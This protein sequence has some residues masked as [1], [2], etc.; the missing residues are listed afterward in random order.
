MKIKLLVGALV[1]M[2]IVNLATIGSFLYTRMTRPDPLQFISPNEKMMPRN[3]MDER[4]GAKLD[5]EQWEQL[6][7]LLYGFREETKE[8]NT[9]IANLELETLT[10]L[11]QNPIPQDKIQ[12]NLEKISEIKLEISK[13]A[14]IK[15]TD[16]KSFLNPDQELR[17]FNSIMRAGPGMNRPHMRRR[18]PINVV[19]PD[20]L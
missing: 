6:R 3:R 8:L 17:F 9:E 5:K 19:K 20:T 14:I 18:E 10:M 13:K 12:R 7:N 11:Q 1:F 4:P 16:A 15:I 2:I